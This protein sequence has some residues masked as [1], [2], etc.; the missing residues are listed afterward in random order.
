MSAHI[1]VPI[2]WYHSA[3]F[4]F[5]PD[6][7]AAMIRRVYDNPFEGHTRRHFCGFCGTPLT[8]WSE[9][10]RGEA[11]YIQVTMGSL[12]REDVGDLEEL[13]LV[14]E[15][16]TSPSSSSPR[17]PSRGSPVEGGVSNTGMTAE[18]DSGYQQQQQPTTAIGGTS[19]ALARG[20]RETT[21]IPW[22]DTLLEGSRLARR[23]RSTR[24]SRQ[25]ADGTTRVEWEIVEYTDDPSDPGTPSTGNGKRK[26]GDRDDA[27]EDAQMEGV[28]Q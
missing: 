4:S 24:G 6:E 5:F 19:S 13:G 25:S 28:G 27:D 23:V 11:N 9:W 15:T 16:P 22:F 2:E 21:T 20:G 10:P 3:T 1:R 14:T 18:G 8:Y 17:G 26:L 7:T 12:C